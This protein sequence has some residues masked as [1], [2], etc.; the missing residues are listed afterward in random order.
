M[1]ELHLDK[2]VRVC[3]SRGREGGGR[4]VLEDGEVDSA[5]VGVFGEG[6]TRQMQN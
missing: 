6:S 2:M 1:S 4:G 3:L 5:M